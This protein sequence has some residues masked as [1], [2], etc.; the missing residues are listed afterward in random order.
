MILLL[1]RDEAFISKCDGDID[2]ATS[3]CPNQITALLNIHFVGML[4]QML[5]PFI[6]HLCDKYGPLTMMIFT[7]SVACLGVSLLIVSRTYAVDWVLYPTFCFLNLTSNATSVMIVIT[8]RYFAVK[9]KSNSNAEKEKQDEDPDPLASSSRISDKKRRRVIGLLNN[10]FDAGS[11]TYLFLWQIQKTWPKITLQILAIGYLVLGLFIF[12]GALFFWKVLL[13]SYDVNTSTKQKQDSTNNTTSKSNEK[14]NWKELRS[15]SFLWLNA[16]F[17][18]HICRNQ[19]TLTSAEAFLKDL[20]DDNNAYIE[21]FTYIMPVSVIGLP[22][23]DL[24]IGKFGYHIAL[25]SINILAIA[26]GIIQISSDNLNIQIIGFIIFSFYR[27]FIF[28]V[29]FAFLSVLLRPQVL[30]KANGLMHTSAGLAG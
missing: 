28:S 7:S 5:S 24:I 20:G 14:E 23:V 12:G 26:H 4:M 18:F 29:I 27:C 25:Q 8:G 16:F 22:L 11:V 3:S 17:A 13:N 15:T 21:I 9:S 10:L 2:L 19:F 6:G 30:G 1:Q